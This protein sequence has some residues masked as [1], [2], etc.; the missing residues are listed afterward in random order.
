MSNRAHRI[1]V[2]S[3]TNLPLRVTQHKLKLHPSAFTAR[4]NFYRLVWYETVDDLQAARL[5]ELEIKGWLRAKKVAL[6][7]S[8]NPNWVDL[9]ATWTDLLQLT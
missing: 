2:G 8:K 5:R 4:Y 1:Y 6:I 9:S 3:T 7:Q